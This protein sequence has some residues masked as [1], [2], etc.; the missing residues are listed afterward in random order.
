MLGWI[1]LQAK[2]VSETI[3]MLIK[4]IDY[5]EYSYLGLRENTYLITVLMLIFFVINNLYNNKIKPRLINNSTNAKNLFI[6]FEYFLLISLVFIFLR[7]IN[8]FIYFQ[9]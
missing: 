1:P 3:N 6:I 8:Q 4:I 9:F 5:R 2:N 7:P